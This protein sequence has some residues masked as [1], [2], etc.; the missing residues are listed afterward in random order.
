MLTSYIQRFGS[1]KPEIIEQFRIELENVLTKRYEGHWYPEKP[2]KG[3]AY[4]SLEFNK[5]N[6][7]C[8]TILVRLCR[9]FGFTPDLLG[10]HHEFTLWIDPYEV[11]TRLGN[12]VCPK[13]NQQI[14][15]AQFNEQGTKLIEQDLDKILSQMRTSSPTNHTIPVSKPTL[16]INQP[17]MFCN[18]PLFTPPRTLS[19]QAPIF[20]MHQSSPI[21]VPSSSHPSENSIENLDENSFNDD[22]RSQPERSDTPHSM[23]STTSNESTDSGYCGYVESYPYYYKLNRLNRL[24]A[25]QKQTPNHI[26]R[27]NKNHHRRFPNHRQHEKDILSTSP[28]TPTPMNIDQLAHIY[29]QQSILT[30]NRKSKY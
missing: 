11:S 2:I 25:F 3:Q 4:R 27:M 20:E 9:Q 17:S 14:I 16:P 1:I 13:D 23:H 26:P 12:H 28:P 18:G 5:E 19:P 24:L 6:H 15:I 22:S 8:D 29:A 30:S 7:F 21:N 10:F